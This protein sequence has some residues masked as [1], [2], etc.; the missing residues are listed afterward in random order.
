MADL[1]APETLRTI[2]V[3]KFR[4][5]FTND[6]GG[7]QDEQFE[8]DTHEF[9]FP[10]DDGNLL[11]GQGPDHSLADCFT[12]IEDGLT[13]NDAQ[14]LKSALS[15]KLRGQNFELIGINITQ[16]Q[17]GSQQGIFKIDCKISREDGEMVV[18]FVVAIARHKNLN[19]FVEYDNKT[20]SYLRESEAK[21]YGMEA[22]DESYEDVASFPAHYGEHSTDDAYFYVADFADGY[23]EINPINTGNTDI[24]G[25][26]ERKFVLNHMNQNKAAEMLDPLKSAK[27]LQDIAIHQVVT[28]MR[29][30]MV[31]NPSLSAG[32]YLYNPK[33]N[34]LMLHCVRDPS[35]VPN[36][37]W[38]LFHQNVRTN[39]AP[40]VELVSYQLLQL[41][42]WKEHN[43]E[44][45]GSNYPMGEFFMMSWMDLM[46]TIEK[47]ISELK[48]TNTQWAQVIQLI[49]M[50]RSQGIEAF[51][52]PSVEKRT[53]DVERM[54][55][56][57]LMQK[58]P[59]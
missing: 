29:C 41:I 12:I 6:F 37:F 20:I 42:F 16:I 1:V 48:L 23:S 26:P 38:P 46:S 32:D 3:E 2:P 19:A 57:Y 35:M 10:V 31:L 18:P 5:V 59:A 36:G 39:L 45:K 49:A 4:R 53:F 21:S 52:E 58:R 33:E 30:G 27:I 43:P 9:P 25:S 51:E 15:K 34:R 7:V 13:G 56:L 40:E 50:W 8:P 54:I 47:L 17:C 44:V 24:M 22:D 55:G 14:L 28:A 11:K